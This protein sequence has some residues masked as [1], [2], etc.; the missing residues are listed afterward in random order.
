M[1]TRSGRLCA[2][3]RDAPDGE[4]GRLGRLL[5]G[6]AAEARQADHGR[7]ARDVDPVGAADEGH[8]RLQAG[9][10][11]SHEH[12]ALHDL[13]QLGADRGRRLRGGVRGVREDP[14]VQ[15]DALASGSVTDAL[16]GWMGLLGHGPSLASGRPGPR[17]PDQDPS[18][19]RREVFLW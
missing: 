3:G 8:D 13:A 18:A 1:I 12:Q 17:K 7:E 9:L 11:W 10:R 6:G 15:P 5:C 14:D 19:R 4:P 16:Q 2:N